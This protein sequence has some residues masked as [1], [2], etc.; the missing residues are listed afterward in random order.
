MVL[1]AQ[2]NNIEKKIYVFDL[3]GTICEEKSK[4]SPKEEYMNVKP[5][6]KIIEHM[7]KIKA[8]GHHIIIHT[9]RHMKSTNNDPILAELKVGFITKEWLKKHN[10]PYD[11]LIF[12]KPLGHYYIDDRSICLNDFIEHGECYYA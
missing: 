12:G 1:E 2:E 5:N 7:H 3:D 6:E 9:A 10:I 8:L 11:E 4:D